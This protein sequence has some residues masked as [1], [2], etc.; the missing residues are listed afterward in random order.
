MEADMKKRIVLGFAVLASAL[1][2]VSCVKQN[3][4]AY[5]TVVNIGNMPMA[6]WV[7]GDGIDIAAYDSQTWAIPLDQENEIRTVFLEAEPFG[8]GDSDEI[9]V[10]LHGDRDVVTWL[11]GWDTVQG[12]KPLKKESS[13]LHGRAPSPDISQK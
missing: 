6:A 3:Y 8:G 12:N 9:T 4:E 5:V 13:V 1:F 7:D 10:A 11:T 2:L